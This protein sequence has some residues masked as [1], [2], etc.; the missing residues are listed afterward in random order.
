ME[1]YRISLA[2][3]TLTVT[4]HKGAAYARTVAATVMD[5]R[6][7]GMLPH[8]MRWSLVVF[9]G[10]LATGCTAVRSAGDTEVVRQSPA[11]ASNRKTNIHASAI[12]K[13]TLSR[14]SA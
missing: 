7:A 11:P 12:R 5:G 6:A 8:M 2:G 4:D 9:L 1:T 13:I 3:Q 14:S 10:M